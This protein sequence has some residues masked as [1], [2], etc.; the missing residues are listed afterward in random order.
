MVSASWNDPLDSDGSL[1]PFGGGRQNL[2]RIGVTLIARQTSHSP[3][4]VTHVKSSDEQHLH[5]IISLG[6][7]YR[8]T[9]GFLPQVAFFQA[10]DHGT[11]TLLAVVRGGKILGYALYALPRQV[12]R[13]TRT[14]A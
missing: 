3:T 5:K 11:G 6:D 8:R 9:L 2:A 14:S 1:L 13:L 12:V 4:A 10:A 7:S